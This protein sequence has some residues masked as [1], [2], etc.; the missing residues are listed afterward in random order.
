MWIR[1]HPNYLILTCK[2]LNT[3]MDN[4][5]T[6]YKNTTLIHTLQTIQEAKP[7]HSS[8]KDPFNLNLEPA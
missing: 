1:T 4:S 5:Q 7:A 8:I 6:T 3:Q 2:R